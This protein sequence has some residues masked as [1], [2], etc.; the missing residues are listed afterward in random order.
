MQEYS[1]T[2]CCPQFL[3]SESIAI[4]ELTCPGEPARGVEATV[5]ATSRPQG[6][7]VL[8]YQASCFEATRN[9][10]AIT[11]LL[12]VT[13]TKKPTRSITAIPRCERVRLG[14]LKV[15]Q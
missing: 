2:S 13:R 12:P 15:I 4:A 11:S 8:D 1:G 6:R 10:Q 3:Q 7:E 5:L 9:G 14:T